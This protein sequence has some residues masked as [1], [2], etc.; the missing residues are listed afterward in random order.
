MW[1]HLPDVLIQEVLTYLDL[2]KYH[3]RFKRI[4]DKK[5]E[6]LVWKPE[7]LFIID[8][9]SPLYYSFQWIDLAN[10]DYE[11]QLAMRMIH[12]TTLSEGNMLL[13]RLKETNS[14]KYYKQTTFTNLYGHTFTREQF[15]TRYR[16]LLCRYLGNE[17]DEPGCINWRGEHPSAWL[18]Y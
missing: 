3:Q 5:K 17:I 8:N 13:E 7:Y 18:V 1:A 6:L 15:D 14:R 12:A 9:Y 4:Y 10:N 2:N 16:H 11:Q